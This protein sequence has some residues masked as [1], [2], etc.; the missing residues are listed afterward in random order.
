MYPNLYYFFK[1]V[2]GGAPSFLMAIQ[3]FGFFVAIAFIT[4]AYFFSKELKRKEDLGLLHAG[5]EKVKKGQPLSNA[6][7]TLAAIIGFVIGYKLL[8]IILNFNAF[9]SNPQE[10]LLS[11]KGNLIGGVIGAAISVWLKYDDKKKELKKYPQP[12]TIEEDVHP[13]QLVGN[14]TLIAAVA[15]L[16]GA[17]IFHNLENWDSFMQDPWG[18]LFS[19][20]GLT[21]YGGLILG[22]AAVIWY[23]HRK[24]ITIPHLID[25]CAPALMLAYGVGRIG[26]QVAGDGDWGIPNSAY[27]T[28]MNGTLV[29]AKPGDFDKVL[30]QNT[31]Y[32]VREFGSIEKVHH[33]YAP[34]PSW[35]PRWTYAMNYAHNVNEAG[36]VEIPN[37]DWKAGERNYCM[38]LPTGV[39]P[40]PLYESVTCISLFFVLWALRRKIT[41]PGVL[42][43]TYLVFNGIERFF[44]EQIRVNT[45]LFMIGD[46][47]VTQAM[48]IAIILI[49][50]GV[51]GI[52]LF[53]RR[54]R[55][56]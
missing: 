10:Y 53:R 26:C 24:N 42:F 2:F 8:L 7:Y 48:F 51:T 17:K 55:T 20:S 9:T 31:H 30:D 1:D 12:V 39:F 37:C 41:T 47:K 28:D 3:S 50:I 54:Y 34:A 22:S 33:A 14:M 6:D 43:S 15:G 21:M 18:N 52:V 44:I 29:E 32:F 35:L 19:F 25:A 45:T 56:A 46:Y 36:T 16:L 13:Y 4:A 5:K 40:T 38:A 11:L 49:L 27:I 23:A